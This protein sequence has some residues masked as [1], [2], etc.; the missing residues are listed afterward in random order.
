MNS[1]GGFRFLACVAIATASLSA[2][3][4]PAATP[5]AL[6]VQHR[7]EARVQTLRE[8]TL[9][10]QTLLADRASLLASVRDQVR[11]SEAEHARLAEQ[12]AVLDA[13]IREAAAR[14]TERL[15]AVY[16]AGRLGSPRTMREARRAKQA[17]KLARYLTALAQ[18]DEGLDSA[19]EV[20]RGS[21]LVAL[22]QA[23]LNRSSME[24]QARDL[25]L[26]L[27]ADQQAMRQHQAL[28]ATAAAEL[29]MLTGA[30]SPGGQLGAVAD[31]DLQEIA[32][33]RDS[34]EDLQVRN[35]EVEARAA[36]A[37]VADDGFVFPGAPTSETIEEQAGRLANP[38]GDTVGA[39]EVQDSQGTEGAKEAE[40][41][42]LAAQEIARQ[43]E[44][45]R[46]AELERKAR[47]QASEANED[48]EAKQREEERLAALQ[49]SEAIERRA[50]AEQNALAE[51]FGFDD[52]DFAEPEAE[53]EEPAESDNDWAFAEEE[54]V[55]R[56][57]DGFEARKGQ[58]RAPMQGRVIARFGQAHANGSIYRGLIVRGVA[59]ADVR[60]VAGGD[61]IYS[62]DFP[63]LG[64]TLI[65]A[66]NDRYH[67]VYAR[68]GGVR[69][70]VGVRVDQ[71][72]VLGRMPAED[73]DLHFEMRLA[74]KPFDPLPWFQGGQGA[75]SP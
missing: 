73:G 34:V 23:E 61:V 67:T 24:R 4:A 27:V 43:A 32:A 62:G 9:D 55:E 26:E 37:Y 48:A 63:G 3:P 54:P 39:R 69:F 12:L 45:M 56:S 17:V 74:G 49:E 20:E 51:A 70:P 44:E 52:E 11:R 35:R 60:A 8:E 25:E 50:E 18:S 1:A 64:A 66:H 29:A 38:Q 42:R 31:V 28:L 53:A 22:E 71:G 15:S 30:G 14:R 40:A 6:R 68:M 19:A 13:R 16:R 10:A 33:L 21:V 41:S 5:A 2:G 72:A 46:L 65:L 7:L 36:A 47:A 57:V 59:G 75:F 58:L